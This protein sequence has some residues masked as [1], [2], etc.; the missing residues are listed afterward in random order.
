VFPVYKKYS[1][2]YGIAKIS[3]F[4][5]CVD[6]SLIISQYRFFVRARH[7]RCESIRT[8]FLVFLESA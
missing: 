8:T 6:R 1:L 2:K 5:K 3:I 7:T 4:Q